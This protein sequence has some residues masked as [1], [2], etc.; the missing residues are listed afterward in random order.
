MVSEKRDLV[1]QLQ[2]KADEMEGERVGE[3]SFH[4]ACGCWIGGWVRCVHDD[5]CA[6]SLMR[7]AADLLSDTK[8]ASDGE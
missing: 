5:D 1:S 3:S 8:G 7:A 2:E 4:L 6:V